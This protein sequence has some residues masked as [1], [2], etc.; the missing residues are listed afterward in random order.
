MCVGFGTFFMQQSSFGIFGSSTPLIMKIPNPNPKSHP[1]IPLFLLLLVPLSALADWATMRDCRLVPS[2]GNDGDSFHFL[3]GGEEYIARLYF[4]DCA[5]KDDQVPERIVQQMEAFGVSED[6]VYRYGHEAK[7]FTERVLAQPFTVITRF[8][9]A[10]GR[11]K[12]PRYYSFIFPDG[13]RQDL[14]TLLT[15]AGLARSFGQ[16]AKNDLRLDRAHYD[17]EEERARREGMGIFGGR[18]PE[19]IDAPRQAIMSS[20]S[21]SPVEPQMPIVVAP[22]LTASLIDSLGADLQA[23]T[24]ALVAGVSRASSGDSVN[25]P[26][27]AQ[28]GAINLNSATSSQLE[29]LPGIGRS[30]AKAI[31]EHRPYATTEDLRRVPRLGDAA[32]DRIAPLVKF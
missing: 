28:P 11:S 5:E 23:S 17:R 7:K 27:V 30:L 3:S 4:V 21:S 6:V 10:R 1:I 15:E 18:K 19:R 22:D 31:I 9:D 32:I 25:P 8:Q 20:A 16:T 12:L 2:D 29:S 26:P 24:D 13:S 14:G